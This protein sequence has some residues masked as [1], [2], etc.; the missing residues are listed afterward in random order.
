MLLDFPRYPTRMTREQFYKAA[1]PFM[2]LSRKIEERFIE[3]FKK[4][5][6]K[7]TVTTSRGNEASVVGMVMPLRTGKDVISLL[8]RNLAGHV[9]LGM[10]LKDLICQYCANKESPTHAREGNVHHG[11]VAARRFPMVSHLG[12]MLSTVVGGTFAARR[13]N[14]DVIGLTIIGDGGSSTGDFHESL[15]MASVMNVPV[16]FVVEN[17]EYAFS[18]P[19]A[20]QYRCKN[21]SDRARG[22]GIP[23]LTIDGLNPWTVYNATIDAID[24]MRKDSLPYLLEVKTVRIDGHAAYDNAEYI[25]PEQR[26]VTVLKD[27]LPV[28]RA[29]LLTLGMTEESLKIQEQSIIDEIETELHRA[30]L[31]PRPDS[32]MV[33]MGVYAEQKKITAPAFAQKNIRFNAAVTTALDYLL[34]NNPAAFAI[35]QDI[36]KYGSAFKT[37]KGLFEKFGPD[38]VI[39]TPICES[40]TAG[41]CLGA[42]QLGARPIFEF[43]FADFSTEAVTQVGINMGTWHFRSGS[44]VPVLI[45]LPTGGGVNLGAFHSSELEG[46]WLRFPGLKLLYPSNPSEVF[47]ALVAGFYDPNPC[48]VLEHKLLYGKLK[49]D[50]GADIDFDGNWQ[51]VFRPRQYLKGNDVTIVSLGAMVDVVLNCVR[52]GFYSADVWNP[53]ILK[54]LSLDPIIESVRRTRR[55]LV[56]QESNDASGAGDYL[57]SR[58]VRACFSD[59]IAAPIMIA[60]PDMPVPFARELERWYLPDEAK[61]DA[62]L[63]TL[64]G[65]KGE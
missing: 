40:A 34:A 22:Y 45:R 1:Y 17:N 29:E 3:L 23:G 46:L 41:F 2:F 24:A 5:Q 6:V 21:I 30:L 57:L 65:G 44:P 64:L 13:N 48:L 53:F 50:V 4:G 25:T 28:A 52:K 14:E 10:S 11:N 49:W 42:S 58:I 63:K 39:D 47:E 62:A 16:L 35:G 37:V 43:Q 51:S 31:V 60:A 33:D 7:G 55:L 20:K 32:V 8:H 26:A 36:G 12:A 38:R 59:L 54:P 61:V 27:P 56:V 15:N 19:T 9:M 18:T